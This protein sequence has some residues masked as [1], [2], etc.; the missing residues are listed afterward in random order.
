MKRDWIAWLKAAGIRAAK[1]FCQVLA[2]LIGSTLINIVD[3]DW[4]TCLGMAATSAVLSLL[5]SV[6]GL[7]EVD[8]VIPAQTLFN[9][10]PERGDDHEAD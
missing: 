7:P 9:E 10:D 3:I 4:R 5:M 2:T 1:T 8:G 6:A